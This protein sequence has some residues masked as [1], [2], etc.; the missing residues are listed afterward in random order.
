MIAGTRGV[1]CNDRME[2]RPAARECRSL[3]AAH[4]I[5]VVDDDDEV[6]ESIGAFFRSMGMSVKGFAAAES[7]LSSPD[8]DAMECLIT[9][10]HMPGM[11][12]FDL[13]QA[14]RL[15]GRSV[16]TIMMSAYAT[17]ETRREAERLGIAVFLEKPADPELLLDRV[18]SL[19]GS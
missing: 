18:E 4:V 12:G 1:R 3:C 17:S 19:L 14:L 2:Q 6:R 15:Q 7:L 11:S 8:L 16:P 13:Q 10:L 5:C 9:D